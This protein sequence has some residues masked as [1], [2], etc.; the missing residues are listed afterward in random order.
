MMIAVWWICVLLGIAG[1]GLL[2][3]KICE[4]EITTLFSEERGVL[5]CP[6]PEDP[7]HFGDCCGPAWNRRC[8]ASSSWSLE[9]DWDDDDILEGT[10]KIDN[11]FVVHTR[12]K[13]YA[14]KIETFETLPK[15]QALRG[16]S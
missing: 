3:A 11:A 16:K 1:F 14:E 8:C 6:Q 5:S 15:P 2:D 13:R 7:Q 10:K 4:T 9:N 12:P